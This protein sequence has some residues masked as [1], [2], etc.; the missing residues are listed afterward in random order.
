MSYK[1]EK[2]IAKK[3]YTA[4]N[5]SLNINLNNP[6]EI[7]NDNPDIELIESGTEKCELNNI[8]TN[9]NTF[10]FYD[11]NGNKKAFYFRNKNECGECNIC[12]TFDVL[13]KCNGCIFKIC[14]KCNMRIIQCPQNCGGGF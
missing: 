1:I 5:I 8:I 9:L 7:F 12:Y 14:N 10:N 11:K 2:F 13:K 3:A 6:N 4:E